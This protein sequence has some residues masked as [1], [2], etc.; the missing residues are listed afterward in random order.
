MTVQLE[1]RP[2]ADASCR[3]S[4]SAP[5]FRRL[6]DRW[7]ELLFAA[8][9][10][11]LVAIRFLEERRAFQLHP[12]SGWSDSEWMIGY[13]AG[14]VRRGLGGSFLV[15]LIHTTGIGFFPLRSALTTASYLGLCAWFLQRSWRLAGPALWRFALLFNPLLLLSFCDY[16][17]IGRKDTFF[18][19]GTLI[20]V[21][22]CERALRQGSAAREPWR[23][24]GVALATALL[25]IPLALLHEGLFLFAW[26]PLN[27]ILTAWTLAQL[28]LRR[29]AVSLLLL[30]AFGPALSATLACAR[31]HGNPATAQALCRSWRFAI[32]A[33]CTPGPQFPAALD[34]LSWSLRQG[35]SLSLASA[36]WFPVYPLLFAIAGALGI[37]TV[38]A[39]LSSARVEHLL[40]LVFVPFLLSLPLFVLGIDWGRW[41]SLLLIAST[42]VMFSGDLRPAL[43]RSLPAPARSLCENLPP[44]LNPWLQRVQ[45]SIERHPVALALACFL[46]QVPPIPKAALLFLNPP[47]V[48]LKFLLR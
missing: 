21:L 8:T 28:G 33:S 24:I 41:M 7:P 38:L 29:R 9:V 5:A 40:A 10:L 30:A 39:L 36:P 18:L 45:R 13:A 17:T 42:I 14:F 35:M 23:R 37:V 15:A 3:R 27:L 1:N 25:S 34:A 48:V 43:F 32:P 12:G 26:L 31:W 4:P 22:I 44:W 19:W 47:V 46:F 20:N 11:L 16:G 6:R 2:A